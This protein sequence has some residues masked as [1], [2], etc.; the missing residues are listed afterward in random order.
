MS[1]EEWLK[2]QG[3]QTPKAMSP[4]DW[5]KSQAVPVAETKKHLNFCLK[6]ILIMTNQNQERLS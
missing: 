6:V 1:P 5:A 4:E 3:S 2:Q